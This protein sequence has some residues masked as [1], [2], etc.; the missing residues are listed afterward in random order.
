MTCDS[1]YSLELCK[2]DPYQNL[3]STDLII[4]YSSKYYNEDKSNYLQ[5]LAS[6]LS[7]SKS[8]SCL[9]SYVIPENQSTDNITRGNIIVSFKEGEKRQEEV[10]YLKYPYD[11]AYDIINLALASHDSYDIEEKIRKKINP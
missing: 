8:I 11:G 7:F 1:T 6:N 5:D 10:R 9:Y 3:D 4:C 2:D